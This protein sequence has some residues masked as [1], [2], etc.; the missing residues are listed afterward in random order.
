MPAKAGSGFASPVFRAASICAQTFVRSVSSSRRISASVFFGG[1]GGKSNFGSSSST[2]TTAFVFGLTPDFRIISF[3]AR[4][5]SFSAR[6][7]SCLLRLSA[8]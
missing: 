7:S 8:W 2:C 3:L 5:R 6:I 4:I 1:S